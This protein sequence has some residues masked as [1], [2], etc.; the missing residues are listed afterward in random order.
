MISSP[1]FLFL[2]FKGTEVEE[3]WLV[4]SRHQLPILTPSQEVFPHSGA[5]GIHA[6]LPFLEKKILAQNEIELGQ[7]QGLDQVSTLLQTPAWLT[8]LS[9]LCLFPPVPKYS[10]PTS[11]WC[12]LGINPVLPSSQLN[13]PEQ[14]T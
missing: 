2:R 9:H 3:C 6:T 11:R 13:D 10:L 5:F 12:G 4:G 8:Y 7:S 14:V 1:T